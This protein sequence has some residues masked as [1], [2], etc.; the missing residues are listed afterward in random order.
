MSQEQL[1][2]TQS[3]LH[4]SRGAP[5]PEAGDRSQRRGWFREVLETLVLTLVIFFGVRGVVQ[6]F[7]VDGNSM[8]PTLQSGELLLVN[9][10]VYWRTDA[11]SPIAFLARG[12]SGGNPD[13][14]LFHAPVPGE[15]VVF[16]A[17]RDPERD[18]IK[19]VIGVP[20]NTIEI[21]DG[22]VW[23]N[24]QRLNEPYLR[25]T[26]TEVYQGES[27]WQVPPDHVFVLGDNRMGSSDSRAWGL[28][29]VD[30][31]VGKATFTYWPVGEWGGI[32]SAV[33]PLRWATVR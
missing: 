12:A 31:I 1:E 8:V 15:V 20:G 5:V 11:E 19:R 18:Y 30:N 16:A 17:P 4:G 10:A 6:S 14:Y 13:R 23:R 21:R 26:P 28:V 32:P 27:R 25:D 24:G 7:R 3:A 9:K 2:E 22:G 33:V 29:P